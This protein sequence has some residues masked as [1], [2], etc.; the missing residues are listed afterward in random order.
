MEHRSDAH[1]ERPGPGG[2]D[3]L[4]RR[5]AAEY[6]RRP[7]TADE[8][9]ESDRLAVEMILEEPWPPAGGPATP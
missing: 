4:G 1:G 9:P 8:L 7:Q 5:I 3:G 6:A 2:F